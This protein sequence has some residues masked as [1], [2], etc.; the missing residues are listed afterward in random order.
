MADL[1]ASLAAAQASIRASGSFGS[2]AEQASGYHFLMRNLVQA[3]EAEVLQDPDF[4]YFRILDFWLRGGGDNPDQRYA[5]S[6]IRGGEAY[7]IWG[8][9]GSARRVEIQLYA[10][11]P[12]AGSGHSAGYLAFEDLV[13]EDDGSFVVE[14]APARGE[15]PPDSHPPINSIPNPPDATT[16]FVRHIYDDWGLEPFGEVHIDRIGFEGRRHPLLEPEDVAR[17]IEAAAA[18]FEMR[19]RTWPTFLQKRYVESRPANTM[20]TLYDTYSLGGA[21]GRWMGGGH[22]DLPAGKALLIQT[23]PT[24]A[25]YQAI[26]LTDMWFDSLEYGNLVSSLN[27]TQS[28]T[29]PDGAYYYVISAEDPGYVN[30]LDTGGLTRGVFLLRYDGVQGI[31]PEEQQPT[32]EL[33][34]LQSLPARI[35]GFEAVDE[36]QRKQERAERRRNLQMR[37]G[38]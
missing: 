30:W 18:S 16:V 6:P 29:A 23:W 28:Q 37:S 25:E 15:A 38:R 17:R 26:Q 24:A 9:L 3:L 27:T 10:G 1:Q 8:T 33:V 22:F 19:A 4:P 5:F 14:L 35:P 7:R 13:L 12:W 11:Q 32:A 36:I 34:D 31:I 21:R 20:S 2:P